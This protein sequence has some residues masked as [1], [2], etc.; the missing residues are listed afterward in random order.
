MDYIKKCKLNEDLTTDSRDVTELGIHIAAASGHTTKLRKLHAKSSEF[1]HHE[2]S[3]KW[4]ALHEASRAGKLETVR[5]LVEAGAN[6]AAK[7]SNGA[8]ALWW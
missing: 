4:Q 3:N 7:T 5:F 1:I 8:T 2:D 6:V